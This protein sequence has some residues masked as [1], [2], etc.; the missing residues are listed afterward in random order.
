MAG[1]GVE[2]YSVGSRPSGTVNPKAVAAMRQRVYDLTTHT[3][4]AKKFPI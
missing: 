3:D 4:M 2:A 1:R